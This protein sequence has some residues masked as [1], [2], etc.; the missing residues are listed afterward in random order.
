M[1]KNKLGTSP[2]EK[3]PNSKII[4][5][6]FSSSKKPKYPAVCEH[7]NVDYKAMKSLTYRS[8]TIIERLSKAIVILEERLNEAEKK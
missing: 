4:Q 2:H 6:V 8:C 7:N 3:Y 1:S 5:A